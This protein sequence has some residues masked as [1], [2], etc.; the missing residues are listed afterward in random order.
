MSD[1]T[2]PYQSPETQIVPQANQNT[3]IELTTN[4]L[5]YLNEASPWLRFVGILGYI[6]AGFTVFG[7][8]IGALGMLAADSALDLSGGVFGAAGLGAL[9]LLYIPFGALLF[10]PAH[11]TYKFGQK[12][13]NYRFT[14]SVNDLEE[15]LKNNKSFWKFTGILYI[16]SLALVP[17]LLIIMIIAGIAGVLTNF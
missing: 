4:M 3:G 11:F 8:I 17:V 16:I 12:I 14:N 15:A 13:R 9:F 7:G 6:G 10:L 1:F 2:N 5:K